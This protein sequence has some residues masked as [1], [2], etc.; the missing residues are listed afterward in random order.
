[1]TIYVVTCLQDKGD[2]ICARY[3]TREQA[4]IHCEKVTEAAYGIGLGKVY[5]YVVEEQR[6]YESYDEY[7]REKYP[8]EY[9]DTAQSSDV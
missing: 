7:M 9:Q 1:M 5:R 4:V 6:V 8:E 3:I 2:S